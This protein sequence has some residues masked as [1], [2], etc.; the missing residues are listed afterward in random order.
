MSLFTS[1]R[2]AVTHPA[3]T[4]NSA[5]DAVGLSNSASDAFSRNADDLGRHP[6]SSSTGGLIGGSSGVIDFSNFSKGAGVKNN[7]LTGGLSN[8]NNSYG[9]QIMALYLGGEYLSGD[10]G[11]TSTYGTAGSDT[12]AGMGGQ[13]LV[14]GQTTGVGE[15][16]TSAT[17]YGT[18]NTGSYAVG[19]SVGYGTQAAADPTY[20]YGTSW[21]TGSSAAGDAGGSSS[22]LT[23]SNINS[24]VNLLST[25]LQSKQAQAGTAAAA[26]AADPFASQRPM[27]QQALQQL[28]TNPAGFL[29]TPQYQTAMASGVDAVDRSAG[30]QH[31]LG[32][33][34]RL[35]ELMQYGQGVENTQF[36]S[37][38]DLLSTLSG[39]K[40]GS[41]AA[42]SQALTTGTNTQMNQTNELLKTIA[43]MMMSY[44]GYGS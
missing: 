6:V 40:T 30:A 42:A 21:G 10:S 24:G 4:A 20:G 32:S 33:G 23:S 1:I 19:D 9:A 16:G 41:P 31:L 22:L 18:A 2:D 13:S 15:V 29:N 36:N 5:L 7:S 34:N 28:M 35:A 12:A 26:N 44:F 14:S 25:Y 38:A 39:A 37:Y 8:K 17:G 3:T 11:A 27:Y 43:P